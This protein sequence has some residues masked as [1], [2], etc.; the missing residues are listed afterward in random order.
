MGY[1]EGLV[2]RV[3]AEISRHGAADEARMFGG[4]AFLLA[5]N[6]AVC[7]SHDGGLLVRTDGSDPSLLDAD[8]VA[9]MV[10]GGRVSRTWLRVAPAGLSTDEELRAWVARGAAVAASLPPKPRHGP[11]VRGR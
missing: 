10:M 7:A 2:A 6:M 3:R 8:H 5:G 11:A 9:P 4:H 1:D